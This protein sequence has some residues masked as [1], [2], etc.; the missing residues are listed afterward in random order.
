MQ[1][2]AHVRFQGFTLRHSA[3]DVL[4]MQY[5]VLVETMPARGHA[6]PLFAH[7]FAC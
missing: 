4:L 1:A 5:A 6:R 2:L 3:C 7:L